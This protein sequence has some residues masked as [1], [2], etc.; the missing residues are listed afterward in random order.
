MAVS[1][2]MKE[3]LYSAQIGLRNS[4]QPGAL[5]IPAFAGMT[6]I[7]FFANHS[8]WSIKTE[9]EFCTSVPLY[10]KQRGL[11]MS[12]GFAETL[13]PLRHRSD[14]SG[15]STRSVERRGTAKQPHKPI[16]RP[17]VCPMLSQKP[18]GWASAAAARCFV[19]DPSR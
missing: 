15:S 12:E 10:S 1:W 16:S 11:R 18:A 3:D 8:V 17:A 9:A 14:G 7:E 4:T 5:W 2:E 6:V 13:S 19:E